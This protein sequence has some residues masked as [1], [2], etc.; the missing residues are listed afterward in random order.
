MT[1]L[2]QVKNARDTATETY[3]KILMVGPT[4]SGKTAQI[5]TLPGKVFAYMFDPN[6]LKTI[7]GADIDYEEWLP[8]ITEI[9]MG[10]KK[11][12]R[13]A[14][15]SDSI[16]KPKEPNLYMNWGES[17]NEKIES[18]F[19]DA[20]DWICFDSLTLLQ[21]ALFDRQLWVAKREG[22]LEDLADYRIVGSKL[23]SVFRSIFSLPINIYCTGHL[24]TFQDEKTKKVVTLLQLPGSSRNMIPLLCTNI[25][26]AKFAEVA[27]KHGVLTPAWFIRTVPETRGLQSIRTSVRGL[28]AEE[29]VTIK[30]W[31]HPERYGIGAILKRE[32]KEK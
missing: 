19:F 17:F 27:D 24:Q 20:Y 13:D 30:D 10:L 3:E 29:D 9:D 2:E 32:S 23:S 1:T 4:G 25:W 31:S 14:R 18:S 22:G 15:P 7:A 8:E 16:G 5:L 12:Y 6:S 21:K 28:A 11:F 26:L